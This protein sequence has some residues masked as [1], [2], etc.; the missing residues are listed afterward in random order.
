MTLE[1]IMAEEQARK[2]KDNEVNSTYAKTL[3]KSLTGGEVIN[4]HVVDTKSGTVIHNPLFTEL[5]RCESE[6]TKH[7]HMMGYHLKNAGDY[8]Y[9]YDNDVNIDDKQS[10]KTKIYAAIILLVRYITQEK[11]YL[12]DVLTDEHYGVSKEDL[13]GMMKDTQ[14]SH[15]LISSKLDNVDGMLKVLKQRQLVFELPSQKFILS[16]AAKHIVED[17]INQNSNLFEN[18]TSEKN[19]ENDDETVQ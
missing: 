14:Y 10:S 15:I 9:L 1:S 6:Y 16:D 8:F 3:F 18:S 17:V 4:K 13:S 7:Y 12:Y 5:M 11:R 19:E 2:E